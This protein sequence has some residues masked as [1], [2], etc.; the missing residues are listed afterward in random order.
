[1]NKNDPVFKI[2]ELF[3]RNYPKV[4]KRFHYTCALENDSAIAQSAYISHAF[5][6]L[7]ELSIEST[8]INYIEKE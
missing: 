4:L 1:M 7:I 3:Y 2:T 5:D 6:D 8:V